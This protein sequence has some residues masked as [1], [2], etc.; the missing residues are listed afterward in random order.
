[1][2]QIYG[3]H[4]SLPQLSIFIKQSFTING[5]Y[6]QRKNKKRKESITQYATDNNNGKRTLRLG[7]DTMAHG[8]RHQ[9]DSS[10]SS[11]HHNRPDP[12]MN[13]TLHCFGQRLLLLHIRLFT[14]NPNHCVLNADA[15]QGYKTDPGRN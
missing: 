13:R 15:E 8:C 7:A 4:S 9:S 3:L 11:R 5:L 6:N 2:V 12:R 1:M 10:H 14:R